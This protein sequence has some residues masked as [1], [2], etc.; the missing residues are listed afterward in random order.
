MVYSLLQAHQPIGGY[1]L[2]VTQGTTILCI[3]PHGPGILQLNLLPER[4]P[5]V[6]G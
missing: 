6:A 1:G 4:R 5:E 3:T 2:K